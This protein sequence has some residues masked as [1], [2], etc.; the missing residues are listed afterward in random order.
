VGWTARTAFRQL[1]ELMVEADL[2][3]QEATTARGA[4]RREVAL[5]RPECV[6]VTGAAASS[7]ALSERLLATSRRRV[8]VADNFDRVSTPV[9]LKH[10]NLTTARR[11][12]CFALV[13]GD[14]RDPRRCAS[15]TARDRFDAIVHLAALA[16]VRP[17]LERPGE[18]CDV[19]VHGTALL[20]EAA[21]RAVCR[22]CVRV[23]VV[24]V[25]AAAADRSAKWIRSSGPCSY[26][27]TKRA[28]ELVAHTV[29]HAYGM[30]VTCGRIFTATVA[31]APRPGVRRCRAPAR[32]RGAA[33][34][35]RRSA[36]RDF[37]FATTSST[38][39]RRSTRDGLRAAHFAGGAR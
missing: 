5:S 6:L 33:R 19:N 31:P 3:H 28:G 1:V 18:Y 34:L 11:S 9:P 30:S 17:S 26:A 10:A 23:V 15:C 7:F 2:E 4:N 8:I 32:G 25:M 35:R 14:L 24:G 29:H 16:G 12:D 21:A 13:R 37:T 36:Q 38:L 39:V 22:A 20:L 27:A